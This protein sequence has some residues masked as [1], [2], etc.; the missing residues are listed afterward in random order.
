MSLPGSFA[1]GEGGAAAYSIP[2]AVPP[3]TGGMEPKLT[4]TYSSQAGNG[5]VGVG[6]SLSGLPVVS[7]CAR[8]MAQD[9]VVGGVNYDANDRFCLDGQRLV[10]IAGG[11]Y[12]ADLTEYR[13]EL[14]GFSK[15][16]SHG[17]AG[18]GPAWFEVWSKAGVIMQFGNT[19]DS[20][21]EAQGSQTARLWAVNKVM[22]TTGN[23]WT[24]SYI[25][26]NTN[27]DYRPDRIDYTGN[28]SPSLSPA[29]APYAS[30][31]F[32]YE[33]RADVTAQY[34]AGS[35]V[36]TMKRLV[37]IR[38]LEGTVPVREYQLQYQYST[39]TQRSR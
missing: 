38:T 11:T 36:K 18:T 2:I 5:D 27:G 10:A 12:G 16:V 4:L 22:D 30:V 32:D 25:E 6:W 13:T 9:G 29:L 20:R 35:L 21:I 23:Y 15:I 24:V 19:A 33:D 14:E 39:T 31:R 26:D 7:R 17:T 3:G 28:D 37:K 1:V 34:H 8:T